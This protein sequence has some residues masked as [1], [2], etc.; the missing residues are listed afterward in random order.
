MRLSKVQIKT[1]KILKEN[2]GISLYE[3]WYGSKVLKIVKSS[4]LGLLS[5]FSETKHVTLRAL[6][7]R[8]LIACRR[9]DKRHISMYRITQAG[10]EWLDAQKEVA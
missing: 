1:L 3:D 10:E 7:K 6:E 5:K 9:T 4:D 2:Y 8:G